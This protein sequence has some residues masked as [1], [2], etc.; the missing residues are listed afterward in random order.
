MDT[1]HDLDM[2]EPAKLSEK[3]LNSTVQSAFTALQNIKRPAKESRS[4]NDRQNVTWTGS[5]LGLELEVHTG[6]YGL[7]R[8]KVTHEMLR[9]TFIRLV[10]K[11]S[12]DLQMMGVTVIRYKEFKTTRDSRESTAG[13]E[14][15]SVFNPQHSAHTTKFLEGKDR[16]FRLEFLEKASR[17]YR[18]II[19]AIHLCGGPGPR[20]TEEAVI[21]LLN[22]STEAVRNVQ[23]MDC[24]IGIENG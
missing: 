13:G 23:M 3:F 11:I 8:V 20:G 2:D 22:S 7:D 14:G 10:T 9:I 24:T 19:A 18:L 1:V 16:R 12:R 17:M 6:S 15:M 5:V 21:R 4:S